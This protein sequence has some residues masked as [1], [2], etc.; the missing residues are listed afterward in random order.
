M[1]NLKLD[2][3]GLFSQAQSNLSQIDTSIDEPIGESSAQ[4]AFS[5]SLGICR[6]QKTI[7]YNE[8]NFN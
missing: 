7:S 2:A 5:D 1:Y 6:Q 3:E 8:G 4:L